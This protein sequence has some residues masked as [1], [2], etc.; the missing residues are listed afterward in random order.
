MSRP[1]GTPAMPMAPLV[2][3]D[4]RRAA[5]ES[6][7]WPPSMTYELASNAT[8][9]PVHARV[10]AVRAR[11]ICW[12]LTGF[13]R[14]APQEVPTLFSHEQLYIGGTRVMCSSQPLTDPTQDQL[15]P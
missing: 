14:P 9:N 6:L 11:Q 15:T 8:L 3:E 2:T 5:F 1:P 10:L 4:H 7:K 13:Q 12:R